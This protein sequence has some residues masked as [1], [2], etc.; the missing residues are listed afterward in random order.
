MSLIRTAM[1][2]LALLGSLLVAAPAQA[3][4]D[5][6]T[7]TVIQ[8]LTNL[9]GPKMARLFEHLGISPSPEFYNCMC[10]GGFH[11]YTGPDGGPCRRIGPLGGVEFRGYSM[12]GMK[13]CAAA[14][15][16]ADGRT[17]LEAI[18]DAAKPSCSI[19]PESAGFTTRLPALADRPRLSLAA[20]AEGQPPT[21]PLS[22][23]QLDRLA[24]LY[25]YGVL[26]EIDYDSCGTIGRWYSDYGP[27]IRSALCLA[28]GAASA[29]VTT[30][31]VG[32]VVGKC[33]A[34]AAAGWALSEDIQNIV[35][36]FRGTDT[37]VRALDAIYIAEDWTRID[38]MSETDRRKWFETRGAELARDGWRG[39]HIAD[40]G[41]VDYTVTM[42]RRWGSGGIP[43]GADMSAWNEKYGSSW[44]ANSGKGEDAT[45]PAYILLRLWQLHRTEMDLH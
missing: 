32:W 40:G 19:A 18:I 6:T 12:D 36:L 26:A 9:D 42:T 43:T 25:L 31:E 45:L 29:P 10:P 13:S 22:R 5:K 15:P 7:E 8:S 30:W 21:G 39:V 2:T 35:D 20:A 23:A 27:E 41:L 16:L 1:L 24:K 3:Q 4:D 34:T 33:L 44:Q 11:Y 28:L 37:Y 14:F 17:V 38:A